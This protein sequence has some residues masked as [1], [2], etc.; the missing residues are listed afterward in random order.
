MAK[1]LKRT[2]PAEFSCNPIVLKELPKSNQS[3]LKPAYEIISLPDQIY[4]TDINDIQK[5][6][7]NSTFISI[8]QAMEI[9]KRL[10]P[11]K[12]PPP[13]NYSFVFFFLFLMILESS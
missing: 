12:P 7:L 10:A 1:S 9:C 5:I 2:A 4:E 11:R 6:G 8:K 3:K 13:I